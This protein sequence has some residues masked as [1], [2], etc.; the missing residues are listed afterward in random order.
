MIGAILGDIVGSRFEFHNHLSKDFAF[1]TKDSEFTDDTVMTCAVAQALMDSR[2]D[3]SDLS[4]KAVAAMQRIGLQ[5]PNCGY[6]ARFIHWIFS[7]D[8]QPYNSC[9][10]G[11]A[12]RVS[13]VGFAARDVEEAR[14]LSAAVTR[15]SHDHPEG[16]KGAE[17]TAVAIV[18]ARQ[19]KSKQEIR[20]AMEEYYD[21]S[22]S[23]EDYRRL[24]QGHGKEICQVSLPQALACF[25][26]GESYEDVI[27][28]C[29]SIGGDSDTIAAIAGGI[30][31]AF[32]GVPEELEGQLD[33]Y[34]PSRLMDICKSFRS[35]LRAREAAEKDADPAKSLPFDKADLEQMLNETLPGLT[36]YVRDVNLPPACAEQYKPGRIILER[37]FTDAS[38]RVM[39]MVTTHRY[40]ILSNHMANLGAFEH[41]TNWGLFVAN[42]NAHFKVL[43]VYEYRGRTQILLLHLPDDDR[44]SHFENIT[45]SIEE[46]LIDTSRQR[47]ENKAFLQPIP[48]L[49]KEDWL[50]RCA[51]PLGMDDAGNLF[52]TEP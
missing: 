9:G 25:L 40:A 6:G 3:F 22:V 20:A 52:P 29:I 17:A 45:F 10:N 44:W 37:G 51:F 28:N 41:G 1:L 11:S 24:W 38:C 43:D 14:R 19:G 26:E 30:A 4:E 50:A 5:Y 18:M 42:R 12:M 31:E 34:L 39:G 8:P 49:A 47:F 48:E 35:W 32:Y 7:N 13:P 21:L 36:M 16:M 23:V 46:Q 2:E 33:R 15:I 27:R